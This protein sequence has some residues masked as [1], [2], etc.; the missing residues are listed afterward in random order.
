MS[1]V[2]RV[3]S[4]TPPPPL[5]VD[6][7][8]GSAGRVL[9]FAG[10]EAMPGAAILVV[11]AAQRAGAGLVTLG[12]LDRELMN[13]MPTT[14]PETLY[15]DLS[16]DKDLI[17]SR[18]PAPVRAHRDQV[19]VAGPGM[20]QSGRV[21][22]LVRLL[23]TDETFVGPLLLDADALNGLGGGLDELAGRAAPVILTPHPGE[24]ARLLG[25][26]IPAEEEGRIECALELARRS[27]AICALKGR[28]TIVTDGSRLFINTTGNQ[29]MATAGAGDV[30]CGILGAYLAHAQ[31]SLDGRF[32][33]LEAVICAVHTHGV[34]GDLAR[35]EKGTLGLIASDLIE[36][37]PRAQLAFE[38]LP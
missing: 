21:R 6:A 28:R 8:K 35:A 37:L 30:L 24:A 16:R 11:R 19:R 1:E 33:A 5:P 14:S 12:A 4:V 22:E 17:A 34:A 18:L 29:G 26:E 27:H 13:V 38:R 10:C 2:E 36:A 23:L 15:L 20:G 31:R 9:V 3:E 25:R 7:H 32:G